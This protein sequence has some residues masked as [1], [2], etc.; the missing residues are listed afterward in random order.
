MAFA[1][2]EETEEGLTWAQDAELRVR[3]ALA[4]D[5]ETGRGGPATDG[6]LRLSVVLRQRGA[7]ATAERIGAVLRSVPE[8]RRVLNAPARGRESLDRVRRFTRSEDR[9]V[10]VR[11]PA[12][13]EPTPAGA[14][15]LT[16]LVTPDLCDL[17][18]VARARKE[19]K[20]GH[21]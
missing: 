19:A 6:L 7:S 4:V 5:F 17:E 10:A 2:L 12:L 16:D 21:R 13:R 1:A 18:R 14:V 3:R 9:S 8:A 20:H 11:A 15:P